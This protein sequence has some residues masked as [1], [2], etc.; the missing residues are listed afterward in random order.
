MRFVVSICEECTSQLRASR[1]DLVPCRFVALLVHF[2]ALL[3]RFTGKDFPKDKRAAFEVG[4]LLLTV[5]KF[6]DGCI[7]HAN[8]G[9]GCPAPRPRPIDSTVANRQTAEKPD[10]TD[11]GKAVTSGHWDMSNCGMP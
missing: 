4:G 1:I 7:R 9:S 6:R 3:I 2:V 11:P 5:R 10:V 8:Q